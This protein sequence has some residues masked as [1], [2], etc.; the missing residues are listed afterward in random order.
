MHRQGRAIVWLIV[1]VAAASGGYIWWD[2]SRSDTGAEL[3]QELAEHT[4]VTSP[5]PPTKPQP[6]PLT[7]QLAVN[8]KFPLVKTIHE[9]IEQK[10]ATGKITSHT[11]VQLFLAIQ[12]MRV[13]PKRKTLRVD[14]RRVVY[15]QD[16]AGEKLH[17]D[18]DNPPR[19]LPVE[20][21]AYDGLVGNGFEFVIGPDNKI[22]DSQGF[23]EF[24][25]R[26]FARVPAGQRAEVMDRFMQTT[27]DERVANFIDDSIG[28]LPFHKTPVKAGDTWERNRKVDR[29]IPLHLSQTCTLQGI[30]NGVADIAIQGSV[31]PS[32]TYAPTAQP[33]GGLQLTVRSGKIYGA[34]Q[35]RAK[36]GLP[37]KSVI[38]RTYDMI[39]RYPNGRQ[40]AQTKTS[41]TKIEV[42]QQQGQPKAIGREIAAGE[43]RTRR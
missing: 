39:V 35:I 18:S 14:Y 26:C 34:C 8:E 28:L 37:V 19:V 42:Y 40:F 10:T 21:Q 4:P 16:V 22:L 31:S 36:N 13:E 3:E 41:K 24:L 27:G 17:Y 6:Q 25:T 43:N 11:T 23:H 7:L 33:Q 1:A 5:L 30:R 9:T 2:H 15:D 32:A 38:N 12:V 20:V 29:P